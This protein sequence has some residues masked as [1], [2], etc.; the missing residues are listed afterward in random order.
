[1]DLPL[2]RSADILFTC[3]ISKRILVEFNCST[4]SQ[5]YGTIYISGRVVS[6]VAQTIFISYIDKD[7]Y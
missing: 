7:I 3:Y 5:A 4:A 1:M 6:K 2:L